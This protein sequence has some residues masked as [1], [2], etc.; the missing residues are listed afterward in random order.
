MCCWSPNAT[1]TDFAD[2]PALARLH[3]VPLRAA[4]RPEPRWWRWASCRRR[5]HH[6][7]TRA[8]IRPPRRGD[9][10]AGRAFVGAQLR[11]PITGRDEIRFGGEPLG[12][13]IRPANG[14]R[15]YHA[16][17]TAVFDMRWIGERY[18]PDLALVP[19]GGNFGIGRGPRRQG[20]AQ[21]RAVIPMHTPTP[22][23]KGTAAAVQAM[24][25]SRS[26]SSWPDP[27]SPVSF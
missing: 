18:K 25:T 23:A 22:L 9:R 13:I 26:G 3:N 10:G 15:I 5:W 4:R 21:A 1:P 2:A 27:A 16:G 7:S 8:A 19:I 12:Y 17:D 14:F 24:G 20:V 11:Q 6:A